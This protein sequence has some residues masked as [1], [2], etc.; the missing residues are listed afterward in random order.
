[1]INWCF[2]YTE[3]IRKTRDNETNFK[4][5]L[6]DAEEDKMVSFLFQSRIAMLLTLFFRKEFE[7]NVKD[8]SHQS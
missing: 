7:K 6:K 8:Y 5:Q 4:K 2:Y 1:M 3:Y